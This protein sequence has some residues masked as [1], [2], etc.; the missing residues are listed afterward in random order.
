[1]E[2]FGTQL[3]HYRTRRGL[4][5]PRLAPLVQLDHSYLSL[6]ETD[7]RE[8][9]PASAGR[10]VVALAL[11]QDEQD[12]FYAAARIVPPDLTSEAFAALLGARHAR[13]NDGTGAA[14]TGARQGAR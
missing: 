1:M 8:P 4:S 10:L 5:Q 13:N 11:T 3:R 2:T 14:A 9:S 7:R 6:L 12:G